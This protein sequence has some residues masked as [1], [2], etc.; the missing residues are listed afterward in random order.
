MRLFAS[1]QFEKPFVK[2]NFLAN[3]FDGAIFSFAMSFVSLGA[4]L[5]VFVKRI[6]GSN[7]AIGLIPVIWTIG[8]NVP[9]IFIANYTNK[10]LFKKKLQL[11]MALVQRFPW[12]LLAVISYLTVPTL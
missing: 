2:R 7:L 1:K 11:K 9:Q 5:P 4:V 8:F 6:G 10:R 3:L 12:L